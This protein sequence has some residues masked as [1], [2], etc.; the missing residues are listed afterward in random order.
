MV[1]NHAFGWFLLSKI[2]MQ[3]N[4][5]FWPISSSFI[6][7]KLEETGWQLTLKDGRNAGKKTNYHTYFITKGYG[8]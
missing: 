5:Y 1:T 6:Q 8:Y 4:N 3:E 2:M 7:T